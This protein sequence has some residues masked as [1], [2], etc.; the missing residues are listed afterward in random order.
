MR[1]S[2]FA[3]AALLA[4]LAAGY[5]LTGLTQVRPGERAVVRR[6]GRVLP[7]RP[8][9][10]LWVGL[11]WGV[12]RVDRVALEKVRRVEVGYDPEE[13]DTGMLRAGQMLTGDHNLVDLRVV[14]NYTVKEDQL[15]EFVDLADRADDLVGRAA[16]TA[17]A[18]WVAGR[19]VDQVLIAAKAELPR[20]LVPRLQ[21]RL[22]GLSI[23]VHVQ[24]VTATY[25]LP[26]EQ[27]KDAFDAVTRAQTEIQTSVNK[28]EQ[29]RQ[30]DLRAAEAYRDNARRESA[31]Y[32]RKQRLQAREEANAFLARMEQYH[33]LRIGNPA[34]LAG[35]WYEEMGK[36]YAKLKK[37][38]RVDLLD[39]HLAGDELN[40]TFF[41]P[42]PRK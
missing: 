20:W 2:S 28:A 14:I 38:G 18:E 3:A 25:D 7:E 30:S 23:G 41:P 36:L 17:L 31:A 21:Q 6:F 1:V 15:V 12:E 32:A 5:L 11:P 19:T 35:I 40:I 34:F 42:Q 16:E 37:G 26:P 9:P 33:Q 27:V 4:L 13:D 29:V 8:G 22:D 24:E 39:H 10:G